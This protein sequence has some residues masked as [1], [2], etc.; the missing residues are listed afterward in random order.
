MSRVYHDDV[1]RDWRGKAMRGPAAQAERSRRRLLGIET[2][3]EVRIEPERRQPLRGRGRPKKHV[4]E[5][6]DP[7]PASRHRLAPAPTAQMLELRRRKWSYAQI[8]RVVGLPTTVVAAMFGEPNP[9]AFKLP[10]CP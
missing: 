3:R 2:E 7:V 4:E 6:P 8:A 9:M 5:I 1:V 10:G